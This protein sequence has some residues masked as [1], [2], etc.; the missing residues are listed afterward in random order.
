MDHGDDHSDDMGKSSKGATSIGDTNDSDAVGTGLS[1]ECIGPTDFGAGIAQFIMDID[2]I[3][4]STHASERTDIGHA[5]VT[6]NING[7]GNRD[8]VGMGI[9]HVGSAACGF[10]TSALHRELKRAPLRTDRKGNCACF[11]RLTSNS[12]TPCVGDCD[13][14]SN[15]GPRCAVRCSAGPSW[16]RAGAAAAHPSASLTCLVFPLVPFFSG[17]VGPCRRSRRVTRVALWAQG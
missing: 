1:S 14:G 5:S 8:D 17:G 4:V 3:G 16:P 7:D 10:A 15:A 13:E 9:A 11:C 6:G 2:G 12:K